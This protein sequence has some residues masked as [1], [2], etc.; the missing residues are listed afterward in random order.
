MEFYFVVI[1][2]SILLF[3]FMP[4]IGTV[5][6]RKKRKNLNER[7]YVE[8]ALKQLYD[9]EDKGINCTQQSIAENLNISHDVAAKVAEKINS[10]GLAVNGDYLQLTPEGRSY[11]LRVIRTHR[12]WERYLADKTSFPEHEWHI[13]AELK[14]HDI[15]SEEA[16]ALAAKLGNPVYDPHGDPIPT[17]NGGLPDKK[18]EYISSLKTG[19]VARI[20][21]LEDEPATI[22]SQL[23]AEGLYP[24]MHVKMLE[25]SQVRIK[26]EA[27]GEEVILA[28]L[29]AKNISVAPLSKFDRVPEKYK[30]LLELKQ[31]DEAEVTGLSKACRGTQRRRLMDLG[32]VPGSKISNEFVSTWGDPIAYK[33]RG[34]TIGL[35]KKQA[36]QIYIKLISEEV[37]V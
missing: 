4:K 15:S 17:A 21:H 33:I 19:D 28:P 13:N 5:A 10:M 1:A 35:R 31:G 2:V 25:V 36:Q 26:F 7:V 34:A 14:E 8:D 12:L 24:G 16:E 30:T 6:K 22:Y 37:K 20:V 27:N 9:C 23:I 18:W 3:F 29:F 11:A 32:V